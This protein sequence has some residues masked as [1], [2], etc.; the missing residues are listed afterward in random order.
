MLTKATVKLIQSLKDK[1]SRQQHQ[2]FLAEGSKTIAELL[3][4]KIKVKTVFATADWIGNNNALIT[5]TFDCITVSEKELKQLSNLVT[6]QQVIALAEIPEYGLAKTTLT[7]VFSIVLDG[8]QDPGNLG[9]IIRIAD[10]YGIEHIICSPHC[11]DIYN[12]KVIQATMGSFIR[13]KLYYTELDAFLEANKKIPVYGALMNGNNLHQTKI[14]QTGMLLIGNEGSGISQP[15]LKYIT[16]PITIPR[17]GN[18]ES[19]NAAV[20]T[21]IICDAWAREK[22]S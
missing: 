11:A 13:T 18:A 6:P 4:S 20:A 21:A 8:I 17:R 2:L 19:L 22:L 9:T 1:K 12:P 5:N 14:S 3:A 15:L 10:W 16:Q 7:N